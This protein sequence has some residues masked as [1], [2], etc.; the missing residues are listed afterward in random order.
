MSTAGWFEM[1]FDIPSGAQEIL[2]SLYDHGYEA[3]LVGGCVRDLLRGFRPHDWDICTSALPSQTASCFQNEKVIET[4]IKHGTVTIC[5]GGQ[6]F[7]VTTYRTDG[8]YSDGRRPDNVAFVQNLTQDLARRD[9]TINAMAMGIDGQIHDPFGGEEDLK[10]G[11]IRCVGDPDMRFQEDGLRIMRALRFAATLGFTIH[12]KTAASIDKNLIM[13][14]RVSSER[15]QI[16]LCKLLLGRGC[17]QTMR[18][19]PDVLCR[20]WPELR[21]LIEMEQNNPWH[22]FGGWEH[23]LHAL[24]SAPDN[25]V[26]RLAV[27]LHDIGKPSCK[28]TD[29]N[30]IDH[31][32]GHPVAGA[33]LAD[34]ML[35]ALKFDNATRERVVTLIENH[36]AELVPTEKSVRRWLHRLGPEVFLQLLDVKRADNMG[37][38]YEKVK[39]RLVEF[40]KIKDVAEHIIADKHCF[41]IR[42]LAVGGKDVM[43]V[44]IASGPEVGRVLSTMLEHVINGE[45]PNERDILLETITQMKGGETDG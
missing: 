26:I 45:L 12:H 42:D 11:I 14:D 35:R 37:Q 43:S 23:T 3:W 39:D 19:Y 1:N 34:A 28:T 36:D 18:E 41:S 13:L 31:F 32:C 22:S 9:F 27:L 8:P 24:D 30:G 20:F 16:E 4:G 15:I 17:V 5:L 44:G 6:Q 40:D 25:L 33:R 21:P 7:E 2:Y 38:N 29:A 10:H